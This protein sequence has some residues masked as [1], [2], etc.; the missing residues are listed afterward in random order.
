MFILKR[1]ED[2]SVERC[3]SRLVA[4]GYSQEKGLNNMRQFIPVVR[5]ES[6]RSVIA[7]A[8]KRMV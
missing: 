1:N 3:K 8:S 2:G 5:S 4:Q 7:L 6:I